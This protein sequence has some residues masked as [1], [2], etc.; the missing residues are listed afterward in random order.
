MRWTILDR[1]SV[2][3]NVPPPPW[4]WPNAQ[5]RMEDCTLNLP[6]GPDLPQAPTAQPSC[7][8]Y[9]PRAP[10][11]HLCGGKAAASRR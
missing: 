8:G 6:D 7:A 3:G 5:F 11:C 2:T 10:R 9:Q 4:E 1:P